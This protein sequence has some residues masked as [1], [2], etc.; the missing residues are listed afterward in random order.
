MADIRADELTDLNDRLLLE[1]QRAANRDDWANVLALSDEVLKNDPTRVEAMYLVALCMRQTGNEGSAALVL[2]M[3]S[4]LEPN[5]APIWIELAK[6]LHERHPMEA[7]RAALKANA[8]KPDMP[9][10]LSVLCNVAST[11][12]R[13]AEAVEW[14]ERCESKYGVSGEVCHN[15]SFALMALGRW[16]EGWREFK[17]SLGLP[18]RKKRNYHADRETP[19][20]NPTKHENAVVVIYGEQGI[21]DEIMYASMIDRAIEAAKAKGSRVVIEC[22]SRN[23]GLFR[24]SFPQANVYGTLHEMYSEWPADEGVTHKIEMGGLGEFFAPEPFRRGAFLKSSYA[25]KSAWET[26]LNA[27]DKP[28]H[29][30]DQMRGRFGK[31]RV[32]V[33]WT[34]GSW[35]SGRGRRSIPFEL[36]A[37]MMRGQDVTFVNLEYEDRRKDLELTPGVLN[38]VTATKKGQDMDELAAL[39]ANLDLVISVQTSVVDLAGALGVPCWAITDQ[40]PQWRYTG[41]FGPDTMGFYESV[42][43]YRQKQWGEWAPVVNQIA[44]DLKAWTEARVSQAA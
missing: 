31:P 33:A 5:R 13:H 12:G 44:R 43:V 29:I 27:N 1:A 8:L 30:A 34:G 18:N 19:R 25:V 3:A 2:T 23:E 15:K 39:V 26:W 9:D 17:A 20:W 21:G 4:K 28:P 41:F 14:A 10:T 22:Y 11:I 37:Q 6:C 32:G 24:R 35:E 42:K 40:V 36:I 7:Y 16:A 38:P